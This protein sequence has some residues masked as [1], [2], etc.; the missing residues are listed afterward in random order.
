MINARVSDDDDTGL[1]KGLGNI[2]GEGTRSETSSDRLSAGVGGELE[3]RTV[4][5][6]ASRDNTDIV[7]VF[8]SSQN[9]SSENDLLPGLANVQNM[10]T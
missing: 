5:V 2:I 9:T 1:L 3:D 7:G 8:D 10:D 4:A 6:G